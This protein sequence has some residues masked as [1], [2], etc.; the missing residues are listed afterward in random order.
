MAILDEEDRKLIISLLNEYS[1]K[2]LK[3]C[4]QIDRQQRNL[5]FLWFLLGLAG[6]MW[7]YLFI[8]SSSYSFISFTEPITFLALLVSVWKRGLY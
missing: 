7:F 4:E 1:E 8:F 6:W 2:L 3:I 5:I